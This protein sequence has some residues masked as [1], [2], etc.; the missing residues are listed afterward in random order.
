MTEFIR[1]TLVSR[2]PEIL[3]LVLTI[4]SG[5]LVPWVSRKSGNYKRLNKKIMLYCLL[6]FF[7]LAAIPLII[8]SIVVVIVTIISTIV[9][10]PMGFQVM[11]IMYAI[12]TALSLLAF[13]L[14]IKISKRV[15][16]MMN[17]AKEISKRLYI[18][19][20][21]VAAINIVLMF[22]NL[23]LIETI[24]EEIAGN[25]ALIIS[26]MLQIWWIYL[27]ASLV[28]RASE[29]V[30][31]QIKITML[32]GEIH[33][34]DCSPKVCRVYRNYIRILKRDENDVVIQELQI[35]EVAIRQ[36]EYTK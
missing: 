15:Q 19:F 23:L 36:I 29:Y 9:G 11:T 4:T 16:I 31:S 30:Y 13:F 18:M 3:G 24:H 27:A 20:Q 28:W 35:N 17:K 33:H 21:W 34:F 10:I 25:I 2:W 26:W 8:L 14:L 12:C 6:H 32:D 5:F 1:S 22:L 7:Y